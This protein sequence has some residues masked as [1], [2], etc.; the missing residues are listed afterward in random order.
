MASLII[1]DETVRSMPTAR[2]GQR[3][4]HTSSGAPAMPCRDHSLET[5]EGIHESLGWRL[6]GRKLGEGGRGF[7]HPRPFSPLLDLRCQID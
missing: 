6:G 5:W 2:N 7:A 3:L 4:L 1:P